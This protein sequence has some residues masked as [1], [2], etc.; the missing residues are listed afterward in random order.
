MHQIALDRIIKE[1]T[2]PQEFAGVSL[3]LFERRLANPPLLQRP[4]VL[5]ASCG[6]QRKRMAASLSARSL[7]NLSTERYGS[8][9]TVRS[10]N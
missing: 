1:V 9:S 5:R 7:T 4:D 10:Q 3:P 6:D 2:A 8:V